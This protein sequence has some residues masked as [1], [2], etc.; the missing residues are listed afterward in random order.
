MDKDSWIKSVVKDI[1]GVGRPQK[2]LDEITPC[3]LSVEYKV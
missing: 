1:G 2:T 3:D